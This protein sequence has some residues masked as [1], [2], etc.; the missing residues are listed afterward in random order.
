MIKKYLPFIQLHSAILLFGLTGILG[1]LI[2]EEGIS[3]PLL[4][5][6]RLLITLLSLCVL[7]P[8]K[9]LN[10]F[11]IPL[12][13]CIKIGGI[14][15]IVAMHWVTFYTSIQI[16]NVSLALCCLAASPFFTSI[17]EPLVFKR[18]IA[19]IEIYLGILVLIGFIFV[20]GFSF[21]YFWGIITGIISALCAST[22]SVL[23]KSIVHRYNTFVIMAIEFT[24]G[25]LLLLVCMP[26]ILKVFP[27]EHLIPQS[28]NAWIY[29][30]TLSLLCTTLAYALSIFALRHISAFTSNLSINLEPVY[31]II[32]A[33]FYFHENKELTTGFYYGAVLIVSS[34]FLHP[35]LEKKFS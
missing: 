20:F 31:G 23:N 33:Y 12:Q 29:L 17:I 19:K 24:A 22:F 35:F 34:V 9:M 18:K 26:I 21:Q 11:K 5:F 10:I 13:E 27:T 4:V 30:I 25:I 8:R 16:S 1:R 32:M 6:Y 15:L 3:G 7:F 28:R 14:G 2:N